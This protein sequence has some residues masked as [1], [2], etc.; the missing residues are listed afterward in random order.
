MSSYGLH[1]HIRYLLFMLDLDVQI[2]TTG[3]QNVVLHWYQP[4]LVFDCNLRDP[5]N[6]LAPDKEHS[7]DFVAPY[8]APQAPVGSHHRYVFLLFEQQPSYNFPRCFEHVPPRTIESRAG[9][10][11]KAFMH[12]ASLGPPVA[13]NYFFGRRNVSKGDDP[14]PF[15][16]V[17][18]TSF[19]S[20][21]CD[22]S[23]TFS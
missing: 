4:D 20:L 6:L 7:S 3:I 23:P 18:T 8:I 9:F 11:I 13:V 15:P 14:S 12:A 21:T 22:I 5:P 2:P 16:S 10:D 19:R 1:C 17:T